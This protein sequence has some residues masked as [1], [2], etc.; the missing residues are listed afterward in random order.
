VKYNYFLAYFLSTLLIEV[1]GFYV[2]LVI[3]SPEDSDLASVSAD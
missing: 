1:A 2:T 3:I